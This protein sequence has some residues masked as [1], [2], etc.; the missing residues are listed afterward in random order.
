MFT[1]VSIDGFHCFIQAMHRILLRFQRLRGD[2]DIYTPLALYRSED[3][4]VVLATPSV[5]KTHMRFLA[6]KVYGIDPTTDEG[7]AA[8]R[9]W[10]SHSLRVG[11]CVLLHALGYSETQL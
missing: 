9:L 11:A 10:S 6:S 3:G 7:K 8:L 2:D 4:S 1:R 5:I